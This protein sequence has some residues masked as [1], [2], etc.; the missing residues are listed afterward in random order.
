MTD[1]THSPVRRGKRFDLHTLVY[2]HSPSQPWLFGRLSLKCTRPGPCSVAW[3][4]ICRLPPPQTRD[5]A[6]VSRD[7]RSPRDLPGPVAGQRPNASF[8]FANDVACSRQGP[9]IHFGS[10]S[11]CW[12]RSRPPPCRAWSPPVS[13]PVEECVDASP[14]L[15]MVCALAPCVTPRVAFHCMQPPESRRPIAVDSSGSA[16][17]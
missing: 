14:T 3:H 5:R 2:L 1:C 17:T 7:V 11:L 6:P 12:R 10:R 9:P 8:A 16:A 4:A 13:A 15:K